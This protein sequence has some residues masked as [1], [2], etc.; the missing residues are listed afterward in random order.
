VT[1]CSAFDQVS[2][3]ARRAEL[4]SPAGRVA[5]PSG[6]AKAFDLLWQARK[7]GCLVN[8]RRELGANRAVS[9]TRDLRR[10]IARFNLGVKGFRSGGYRLVEIKP[11]ADA[12]SDAARLKRIREIIEA[13]DNRCTAADGP[14]TPTL[15]EMT[16]AELSRIYA[17]ACGKPE[18]WKPGDGE[19]Y[20]AAKDMEQSLS[21]AFAAVRER[22]ANGGPGWPREGA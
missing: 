6:R 12:L 13:V 16:Q 17:L 21:D 5:L 20:D 2:W 9:F 8:L 1:A 22:K 15:Q 19:D 3:D 4:A 10:D 18:T 7:T 11:E 14:V